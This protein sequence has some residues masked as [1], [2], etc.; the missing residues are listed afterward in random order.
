MDRATYRIV[1]FVETSLFERRLALCLLWF[2]SLALQPERYVDHS[3]HRE[4]LVAVAPSVRIEVLDWGGRGPT[5]LFLPG[6]NSN[7]HAY[8]DI[9]PKLTSLGHVVA[10]TPRGFRPSDAPEGEYTVS[11][12]VEDLRIVLDSLAIPKAT[13]IGHSAAG[14]IITA[15]AAQYPDRVARLVYLDA[16]FDFAASDSI[17]ALRPFR[18][19]DPPADTSFQAQAEWAR[20]YFIGVYT[21]ALEAVDRAVAAGETP[22]DDASRARLLAPLLAEEVARMRSPNYSGL[23]V[24]ALAICALATPASEYPWLTRDSLRWAAAERYVETIRRPFQRQQCNRFLRSAPHG[25]VVEL[26]G[27]HFIFITREREVV[28]ALSAFL[29][30]TE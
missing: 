28:H 5:L 15:F 18:R 20:R 6:W 19:P 7:A 17:V 2:A 10:I 21:P 22:A 4:R 27:S 1:A 23:R 11:R 8:D 12:A 24:P 3:P 26:D 25:R 29:S 13:I 16:S 30:D 9:A 14:P